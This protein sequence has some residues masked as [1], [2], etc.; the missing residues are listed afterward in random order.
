MARPRSNRWDTV[1]PIDRTKVYGAATNAHNH[2][3]T[4]NISVPPELLGVIESVL[5][6]YAGVYRSRAEFLRDAVVH[7]LA[8]FVENSNFLPDEQ[9]VL[10]L[11]RVK[12]TIEMAEQF[13]AAH[14]E[15][16][17]T[18]KRSIYNA[19][20]DGDLSRLALCINQAVDAQE[21]MEEPWLS[22]WKAVEDE[23]KRTRALLRRR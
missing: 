11:Y 12:V 21:D 3:S 16:I 6:E 19:S 13:A 2:S 20:R 22:E 7:R 10:N 23:A 8:D 15:A 5:T 9:R 1:S 4:L 14:L 18:V 17:A